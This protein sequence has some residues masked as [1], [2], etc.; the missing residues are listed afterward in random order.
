[1][2][3]PAYLVLTLAE[4]IK[5]IAVNNKKGFDLKISGVP[6][7]A[8]APLLEPSHVGILPAKIP[9]IKPRLKVQIG[10]RVKVGTPLFEDKRNPDI[11]FLAPGGGE[12]THID[13]GPRRIIREIVIRLDADE[14]HETFD[15]L[16]PSE[17]AS[18]DRED[19][20]KALMAGGLW[21]FF[22]ALPFRDIADPAQTPPALF[23]CLDTLEP[24]HPRAEIFLKGEIELLRLGLEILKRLS[25]HVYVTA[26]QANEPLKAQ[27][28]GELSHTFKGA[29]PAHDPG[30]LLY[31]IKKAPEENA[32]WFIYGQDVLHLAR[33]FT[34]GQYPIERIVTLGGSA[35]STGRHLRTRAGVPL[36]HLLGEVKINGPA[37]FIL[38]GIFTG[39]LGH[40]DSYMGFYENAL[41][42]IP[43]PQDPEAF[44]FARPGT[45][46]LSYSKTFLSSL[47]QTAL[48]GDCNM[49]GEK[50][51]CVNCGY[52]AEVCPVDMLPQ[53]TLICLL[54]DEIEEA[55]AHGLLDCV[56]CGLCTYVCPSKIELTETLVKFKASYY[57]E[58]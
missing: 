57:K 5:M 19:L 46:K 38:G 11:R 48:N 7:E 9:F 26:A 25:P 58:R 3:T 15:R 45:G 54:A 30:V 56:Q 53:F 28:N 22:R 51:A 21:P 6:S 1:M 37:R 32:A 2:M 17:I 18:A 14:E 47:R 36:G 44:A 43:A 35:V 24:F 41:N 23:V 34:L 49:H 13:F 20:V 8:L 12:V 16:G 27:L 29:Y 42:V 10:T 39:C 31:H 40:P 55:L 52:C 33:F 50:R 4:Q